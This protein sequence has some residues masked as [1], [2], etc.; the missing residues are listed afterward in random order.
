MTGER[1][2]A[3]GLI[4]EIRA[5]AARPLAK[6]TGLAARSFGA[7]ALYDREVVRIFRR[8]WLCGGRLDQVPAPG[9]R[10]D[11]R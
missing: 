6:A 9:R 3:D 2:E 4:A 11:G 7:G 10:D 1:F 8:D 5:A